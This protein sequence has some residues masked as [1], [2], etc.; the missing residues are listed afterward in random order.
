[1]SGVRQRRNDHDKFGDVAIKATRLLSL[2]ELSDPREAWRLAVRCILSHSPSMMRKGCPRSAYL[3]LC[4]AG[5]VKGARSGR[6]TTS[7]DN[8]RYAVRAVAALRID[9]TW[10]NKP[11]IHL[12][13]EVSRSESKAP[14]SQIDVVFALWGNDLISN[15][16]IPD[17]TQN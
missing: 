3:G 4:E 12:W 17:Q 9:P 15:E 11:K 10:I 14:N 8:K 6:W 7:D 2:A 13:R 1:M 16:P 5:L